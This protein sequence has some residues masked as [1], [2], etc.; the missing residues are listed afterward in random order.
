MT[1]ITVVYVVMVYTVVIY[2]A[3]FLESLDE[4][5]SFNWLFSVDAAVVGASKNDCRC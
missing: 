5:I 4:V 2:I 1:D 3:V